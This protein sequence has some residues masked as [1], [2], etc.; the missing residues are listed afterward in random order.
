MEQ[1]LKD[2]SFYVQKH[3]A[4]RAV[5]YNFPVIRDNPLRVPAFAKLVYSNDARRFAIIEAMVI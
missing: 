2:F 4:P 3:I 1:G 5:C